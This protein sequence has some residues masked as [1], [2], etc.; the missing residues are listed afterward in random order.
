M[1]MGKVSSITHLLEDLVDIS[2]DDSVEVPL[3]AH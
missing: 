2:E 1:V 3:G